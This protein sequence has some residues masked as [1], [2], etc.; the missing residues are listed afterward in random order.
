M[1]PEIFIGCRD[2]PI[3]LKKWIPNLLKLIQ[4][5]ELL[6]IKFNSRR[7]LV[8][9]AWVQ[10]VLTATPLIL[11]LKSF[12]FSLWARITSVSCGM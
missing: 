8:R 6:I 11:N 10:R 9:Y 1:R 3:K 2:I 4:E 7:H 12:D 5:L